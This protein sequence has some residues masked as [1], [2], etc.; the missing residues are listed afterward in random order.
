MR[1]IITTKDDY[2]QNLQYPN[3][4]KMSQTKGGKGEKNSSGNHTT[5]NTTETAGDEPMN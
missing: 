3:L 4:N 1:T 2:V 5:G